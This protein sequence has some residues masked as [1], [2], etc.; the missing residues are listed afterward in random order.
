M[1]CV[2]RAVQHSSD[3]AEVVAHEG[4]SADIQDGNNIALCSFA[5]GHSTVFPSPNSQ[6]DA[7]NT[8]SSQTLS[9]YILARGMRFYSVA[10]IQPKTWF[11]YKA[12]HD[13]RPSAKHMR[14][15]YNAFFALHGHVFEHTTGKGPVGDL[16]LD[17]LVGPFY[18]RLMRFHELGFCTGDRLARQPPL[19]IKTKLSQA[20]YQAHLPLF[21]L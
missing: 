13:L 20:R 17:A 4:N 9:R 21:I 16:L 1:F 12:A 19:M 14:S 11:P 3:L 8:A 15:L 7:I 6:S 2:C 10:M 5:A 18:G